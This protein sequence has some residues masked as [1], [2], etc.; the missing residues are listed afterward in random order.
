M[1]AVLKSLRRNVSLNGVDNCIVIDCAAGDMPAEGYLLPGKGNKSNL[2]ATRLNITRDGEP[3]SEN[4][5]VPSKVPVR[6]IDDIFRVCEVE[7]DVSLLKLDIEG[8]ELCALRG[9]REILTKHEPDICIELWNDSQRMQISDFLQSFGYSCLCQIANFS[10]NYWFIHDD[11]RHS[12]H[13]PS[14]FTRKLVSSWSHGRLSAIRRL[15]SRAS[16]RPDA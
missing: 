14:W 9:A 7:S 13:R 2:G 16:E 8:M 15:R 12:R 6:P 10:Q 5:I 3:A 4:V 1:P 11:K